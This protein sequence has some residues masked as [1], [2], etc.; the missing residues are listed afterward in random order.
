MNQINIPYKLR[1]LNT[2]DEVFEELLSFI[3]ELG[4]SKVALMTSKTPN[5]LITNDLEN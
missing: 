1:I 3:Q 4:C 2:N 5:H